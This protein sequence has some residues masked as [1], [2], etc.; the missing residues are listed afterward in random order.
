[1][2]LKACL[3]EAV[4]A[5]TINSR[6]AEE[7]LAYYNARFKKNRKNMTDA[8]AR[9]AAQDEVSQ[10]LRAE[11]AEATR[12]AYLAEA[13][14]KGLADII[15]NHKGLYRGKVN[16]LD[17][18]LSVMIHGGAKGFRSM[19]GREHA[20]ISLVHRD[21]NEAM[22]HFRRTSIKGEW[23]NQVDLPDLVRALNQEKTDNA[24]VNG[25]ADSIRNVFEDLRLRFNEAGGNI[26]KRESWDLTHTHDR[27]SMRALNKDQDKARAEWKK[28][29][30]PLLD[31]DQMTNP[32]TGE[33]IG[34]DGL[35]ESLNYVWES[36]LSDGWAHHK[37]EAR[38]FGNG[39][40][41][42]RYQDSRF[43]EFRDA[44]SWLAYNE[45]FGERDVISTIFNQM[46]GMARDIAAMETFGPNPDAMIEWMKQAIRVE[47][48]KSQAGAPK[49]LL[50]KAAGFSAGA[51]SD[52]RID[53]L[54]RYLRGRDTVYQ[55]AADFSGDVRNVATAAML[56]S[57]GVLAATTDPFISAASRALA[58]LPVFKNSQNM[59]KQMAREART[60]AGKKEAAKRAVIWDDYLHTMQDQSRFVDQMM[61]HNWSR[62]LVDRALTWNLL[63]PM[64]EARKRLEASI[65]HAELGRYAEAKTD[66]LDL[67]DLTKSAMEGFGLDADAWHAMRGSVDKAGFLDPGGVLDAT[68]NRDLAENFAEMINGWSER[69]VP[70]GDPRIKSFIVGQTDRGTALGELADFGSQFLGFGMSFTAR[71]IEAIYLYS[72]Q[73]ITQR[74][75]IGRGF[76]YTVPMALGLTVGAAF[77][78]QFKTISDGKEPEEMDNASFWVSAFV[79]G[80]GGGLFADFVAR[81]ENRFGQS[82]A[83][84]IP[85]PGMAL[86]SDSL[87]LTIGNIFELMRGEDTKA[88]RETANYLGRYSP[89]VSS[90]PTTRLIWRRWFVDN[91]QELVD[92]DADKS[93][94]A[95]KSRAQHWWSPGEASPGV[96]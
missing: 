44:D 57:T 52:Y 94:R 21:L 81:S 77:Y 68:G 93:F 73:G 35:D 16:M 74:G 66:W 58:G 26:P 49:S 5:K 34:A 88:G 67:P 53:A 56:G 31:P 55:K 85:G 39:P 38:K 2:T 17:A 64:T 69:S 29:I 82:F 84:Q 96:Q 70:T 63:K 33:L 11:A 23:R 79:K 43:L 65:W 28:F 1:M 3:D 45:R 61:G 60:K 13:K 36:I 25:F 4:S 22:Q 51:A 41:H 12:R 75:K 86:I 87:G 27:R 54:W 48:G 42:N 76:A 14:R 40:I 19:R 83:E 72:L 24:T 90:H 91:L 50:D 92:P 30:T 7:L 32:N 6:Q 10:E 89:I 71:Q 20:I 62:V 80:G 47:I 78:Q 95:K 15:Q 18:A 8:Q 46:N 37:P 9:K 59:L